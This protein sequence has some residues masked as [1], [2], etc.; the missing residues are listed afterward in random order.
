[1]TSRILPMA[2]PR[3]MRT[4]TISAM[5]ARCAPATRSLPEPSRSSK[6]PPIPAAT[7]FRS[8]SPE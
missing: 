6:L 3:A 7:T 4:A 1:M 5:A 2:R 8:T